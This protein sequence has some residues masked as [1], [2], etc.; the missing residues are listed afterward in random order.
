M[1]EDNTNA[2][3]SGSRRQ[4]C[5]YALRSACVVA[6]RVPCVC[7][8][9]CFCGSLILGLAWWVIKKTIVVWFFCEPNICP[10]QE[11]CEG[12]GAGFWVSEM[13]GCYEDVWARPE[14]CKRIP[15]PPAAMYSAGFWAEC[16]LYPHEEDS[17]KEVYKW[18]ILDLRNLPACYHERLPEFQRTA[19]EL[20]SKG[21]K[22]GAARP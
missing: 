10:V 7:L 18:K 8:A 5:A 16:G 15:Y 22:G 3:S 17:E 19:Y 12:E 9:F 2:S 6:L 13:C 4:T 11:H 21:Q 20:K 1:S 14:K